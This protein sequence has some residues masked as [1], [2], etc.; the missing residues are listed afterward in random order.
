MDENNKLSNSTVLPELSDFN[1]NNTSLFDDLSLAT[2]QATGVE[3]GVVVNQTEVLDFEEI[4]TTQGS[5]IIF[6]EDENLDS[7]VTISDILPQTT[8]NPK[9]ILATELPNLE[10]DDDDNNVPTEIP[11]PVTKNPQTRL[12]SINFNPDQTITTTNSITQKNNNLLSETNPADV[13][14]N[15]GKIIGGIIGGVVVVV[16]FVAMILYCA[17]KFK[18]ERAFV[19][20]YAP[21]EIEKKEKTS[22]DHLVNVMKPPP[23]ERLI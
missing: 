16:F 21:D 3:G 6:D 4:Q 23:V 14:D 7:N 1:N 11:I 5:F 12:T 19:G 10:K 2:S 18:Q 20:K 15:T 13:D 17:Y 9:I 22:K 8:I